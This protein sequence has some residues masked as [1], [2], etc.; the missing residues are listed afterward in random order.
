MEIVLEEVYS[1]Y[2]AFVLV[3][4]KTTNANFNDTQIGDLEIN[5]IEQILTKVLPL[6]SL[7]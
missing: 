5:A 3:I 2:K 7:Y 6:S 4:N 1:I